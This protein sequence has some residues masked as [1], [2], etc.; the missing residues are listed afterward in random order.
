[1]RKSKYWATGAALLSAAA[2]AFPVV[3]SDTTNKAEQ[4][5]EDIYLIMELP[6][7]DEDEDYFHKIL[8]SPAKGGRRILSQSRVKLH[9][10]KSIGDISGTGR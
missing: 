8:L 1:M 4:K 10:T 3:A 7:V 9:S 6:S 2:L 5:A